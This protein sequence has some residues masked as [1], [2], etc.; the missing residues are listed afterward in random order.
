MSARRALAHWEGGMG[1]LQLAE[2]KKGGDYEAN[3][4]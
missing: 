3:I 2:E 1:E 4:A